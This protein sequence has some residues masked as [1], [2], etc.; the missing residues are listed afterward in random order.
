MSGRQPSKRLNQLTSA[1]FTEM[2]E[3]KRKVAQR[4]QVIDLGIGSPDK[5]PAPHLIQALVDAVQNPDNYGYPGSQGSVAFRQEVA[6]WYRHRFNVD[7]SPDTEIHA[8]MGSQDGLAHL[9]LAWAD[10]GDIV[11]VPDPGYPIY[12]GSVHLAGAELYPMPLRAEN[13]FL[14]E[15]AAIPAD[16]RKRAKLMILN[17]PNNPVSAVAPLSFFEEVVRFARENDIIVAHDL[18]YSEMAFD[19]YRPPS[20]LEAPGAKEVGIELNSFSKSFNM[21]GCRIAYVVGNAELIKPLAIVKSNIDYGVF[22][23]VQ[24]M[25]VAAL[26]HDRT[27]GE[28]NPVGELYQERRDVLLSSLAEAGWVIE[29][30]KATMF[31]WARVPNGFTSRSFAFELLEKTGVVVIPGDAFGQEGEGYVRIALVKEPDVLR[32]VAHRIKESGLLR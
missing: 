18:A 1:I 20:F 22:D 3:R 17:Y 28:A 19:G 14:P 4:M 11:L 25:A 31:I 26:V 5:P 6:A 8:L 12:A 10:P 29:P 21:A 13:G 24:Q 9:A 7:L 27:C 15:L 23:A 30:P 16:V 32:E 2:A